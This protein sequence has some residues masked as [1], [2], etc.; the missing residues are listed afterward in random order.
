M[1]K[2]IY[3]YIDQYGM[4]SFSEVSFNDIDAVIFSFLSYVDFGSIVEKNRISL[5]N[6][7]RVHLGLHKKDE[8]NVLAVREA[9]KLLKY[10]KDTRRYSDCYL[11]DYEYDI[12]DDIQF[13]AISI[14]YLPNHVFVSFEGTNE[15]ISG[16]RENLV[17]SYQYPSLSHRKAI[18]YLN[19]H[20]T[21]SL[22]R[23]IVGGHSKGG[24]LALVA[25]MESNFFVRSHITQIYNMDGPGLLDKPF[26]SK[27]YRSILS[28]YVHI[29]PDNSMVGIILHSSNNHVIKTSISGPLAH[30]IVYWNVEDTQ[31][32]PAKLSSFSK[33]FKKGLQSYVDSHS[34][35]ELKNAVDSLYSVCLRSGVE[36]LLELNDY[37]KLKKL[38]NESRS[39]DVDARNMFL[40]ILSIFFKSL[41]YSKY[42]DFRNFLNRFLNN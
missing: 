3:S 7:G 37:R 32:V 39:L 41:G 17:L 25:A 5:K 22:K 31:F 36:T 38:L 9:T 1:I 10:M 12:A 42:E 11:F 8:R 26:H 20:F 19:Q 40:E 23:L 24:N 15:R 4:K 29:V 34:D 16:W 21:F 28:K 18:S 2:N 6:V 30:D 33:E 27:K 13:S 14:E 35:L